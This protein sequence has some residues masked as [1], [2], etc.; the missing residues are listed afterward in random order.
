MTN[1]LEGAENSEEVRDE[2]VRGDA[3]GLRCWQ[4]SGE[5][6]TEGRIS[7][8]WWRVRMVSQRDGGSCR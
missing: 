8:P 4:R 5:K 7:G 3:A 6:A 1:T 2:E